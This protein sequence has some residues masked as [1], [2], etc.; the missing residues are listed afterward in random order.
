MTDSEQDPKWTKQDMAF[1]SDMFE[2][3]S[4]QLVGAHLEQL[5]KRAE[6][7]GRPVI[8]WDESNAPLLDEALIHAGNMA[9]R[10][11][12]ELQYRFRPPAKIAPA[13]KPTP[14]RP[15]RQRRRVR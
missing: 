4:A 7:T 2:S 3:Y 11:L 5:N 12:Q 13:A 14:T 10:A 15:S 1:W 8:P 9:D 6:D